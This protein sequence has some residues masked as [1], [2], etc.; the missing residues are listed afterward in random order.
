MIWIAAAVFLG[1]I[2]HE[3]FGFR[4]T[5]IALSILSLS[6]VP[7]GAVSQKDLKHL[8]ESSLISFSGKG[9]YWIGFLGFAYAFVG[10][11]MIISTVGFILKEQAG[12]SVQVSGF[13]VGV[14][15][16]TGIIL[17][18]RWLLMGIGSPFLGNAADRI[19]RELFIFFG[20]LI[21]A[22]DLLIIGVYTKPL[23]LILFVLLFFACESILYTLLTAQASQR[24]TRSVASYVTGV[25]FGSALGPIIGW[26]IAQYCIHTKYIFILGSI[27][28]VFGAIISLRIWLSNIR[29]SLAKSF[30]IFHSIQTM[31]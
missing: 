19:G 30:H 8:R 15:T 29:S 24:G 26:I 17:G 4:I 22:L 28:Y 16:A 6:A 18:L 9:D 3:H 11:G 21:G 13:S 5:F 10:L 31:I 14:V 2:S 20:F 12:E 7:L 27:I 23:L 1:G 25:D